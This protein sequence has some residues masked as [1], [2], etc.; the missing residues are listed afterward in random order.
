MLSGEFKRLW[1][2]RVN[3]V[4]LRLRLRL[5]L[6][7]RLGV[8][9]RV[10]LGVSVRVRLG[11]RLGVGV[12]VIRVRVIGLEHPFFRLMKLS[13]TAL[14]PPLRVVTNPSSLT[15]PLIP[16]PDPDPNQTPHS[17]LNEMPNAV[18]KILQLKK[19]TPNWLKLGLG[20]ALG[21][22]VGLQ[23]Y[24]LRVDFFVFE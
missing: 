13:K 2:G 16:N 4:R 24:V 21:L 9:F 7:V 15:Q 17:K 12:R 1:L 20:L 6:G 8:R 5:R 3:R 10:G 22:G 19:E 18:M 14:V 11:V 23:N